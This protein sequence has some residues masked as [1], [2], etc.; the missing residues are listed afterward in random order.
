[1]RPKNIDVNKSL[2][3]IYY[4]KGAIDRAAE[5]LTKALITDSKDPDLLSLKGLVEIKEGN[6]AY[7]KDLIRSA[8]KTNPHQEA[9]VAV[10]ARMAIS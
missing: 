9:V 3:M 5:H 8:M 2:A 6:T 1:M 4:Q 7:G 10:E